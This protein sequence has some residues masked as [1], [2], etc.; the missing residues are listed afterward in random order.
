[1]WL[2][3]GIYIYSFASVPV[4]WCRS[5]RSIFHLDFHNQLDTQ[6]Q[7]LEEEKIQF[8]Y[9]Y[10]KYVIKFSVVFT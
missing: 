7:R 6:Q 4:L 5:M 1:M 8:T 3:T 10:V 2:P 9:I